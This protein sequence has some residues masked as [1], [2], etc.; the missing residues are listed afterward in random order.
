MEQQVDFND[1][2]YYGRSIHTCSLLFRCALHDGAAWITTHQVSG[3]DNNT[4][5]DIVALE[6]CSS[7]ILVDQNYS[8]RNYLIDLGISSMLQ[9]VLDQIDHR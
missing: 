2:T 3:I 8:R 7:H 1:K 5:E 9:L 6:D 4:E